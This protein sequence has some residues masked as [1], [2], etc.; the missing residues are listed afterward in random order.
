MSRCHRPKEKQKRGRRSVAR[1]NA[2]RRDHWDR[3]SPTRVARSY[4]WWMQQFERLTHCWVLDAFRNQP[5]P[6]SPAKA[7]PFVSTRDPAVR[8]IASQHGAQSPDAIR[9][10]MTPELY[11]EA[12][13]VRLTFES[14]EDRDRQASTMINAL[15]H[16]AKRLGFSA[17]QCDILIDT[18]L[19]HPELQF[20][21]HGF[22][23]EWQAN[24]MRGIDD[25]IERTRR[26][27]EE[28]EP[29]KSRLQNAGGNAVTTLKAEIV[30]VTRRKSR[31]EARRREVGREAYDHVVR[32]LAAELA[33]FTQEAQ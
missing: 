27:L 16:A 7:K 32:T 6:V 30:Q 12:E 15:H 1:H 19:R 18:L 5:F 25:A 14:G 21:V 29:R 22:L 11:Q 23:G 3:R 33:S 31:L 28:L 2:E 10:V 8:E 20:F 24:R 13:S 4:E 17:D 9:R 26:Q